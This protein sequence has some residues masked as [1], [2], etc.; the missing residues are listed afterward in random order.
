VEDTG[1]GIAP[2][3]QAVIFDA[4]IQADNSHSRQYGGTGLGL[5]IT[6]RLVELLDGTLSVSSTPGLGSTFTIC[7]PMAGHGAQ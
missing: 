6:Q 1:I 5:T 2:D 7:L 3:K 4:F